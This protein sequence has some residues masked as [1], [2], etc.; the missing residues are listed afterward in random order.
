MTQPPRQSDRRFIWAICTFILCV[1]FGSF[2]FGQTADA[3]AT[4]AD[5]AVDESVQ[6]NPNLSAGEQFIADFAEW[7]RI[8]ERAEGL[9]E[10]DVA[11]A[12][13]LDRLLT[14]LIVW[15]DVFAFEMRENEAR[16]TTI[17]SQTAALGNAPDE[18]ETEA[19]A[20]TDR[21]ADLIVFRDRLA[22]PG[23]LSA[24]G[25]ARALGMINEIE[26]QLRARQ[27]AALM[28]RTVSPF[29]LAHWPF[30]AAHIID[31]VGA[32]GRETTA[33][34]GAKLWSSE[35]LNGL[36]WAFLAL[37]CA[38]VLLVRGQ[39]FVLRLMPE[40]DPKAGTGAANVLADFF[41]T[42][43]QAIVPL[44][45]LVALSYGL[46][47]L[48]IF[49]VRGMAILEVLPL[50]GSII[51]LA[52][53][54]GRQFFPVG[55]K[56]GPLNLS[57]AVRI[58]TRRTAI[59][60]AWVMALWLPYDAFVNS[61]PEN[62]IAVSVLNFPFIVVLAIVLF[63]FAKLFRNPPDQEAGADVGVGRTRTV[64]GRLTQLIAVV[65]P[66]LAALG[67]DAAA[68]AL[69]FPAGLTLGLLGVIIYLQSLS[70][71]VYELWYGVE[72]A[73]SK[74]L[75]P[76]I[77][78]F[79]LLLL[80]VPIFALIWGAQR[81]DLLA[82]WSRFTA[83]FKWGD[84]QISP[85]DFL[86]FVLIFT[87]GYLLT[88]FI[89]TSLRTSV[90]PRTSLDLGAQD[91][92]VAGFGYVGIFL[93]SVIA[94][95][96]AG[97][98]L[99]N[100][101]IVA[102]A[103][104]V[105]I[106]FGLQTIVSNF[107]SGIILLIERPVSQGDWIEVGDRM[108]YVRSISVRSTRI[109]TFDRTDVIVPNADLISNQ[110]IN[111]TR[112]NLVGRLILKIG[113]AY[114]TDVEVV[115]QILKEIAEAHP[116]VVMTPPP[117]IMFMNFGADALEFEIRAILRDVNFVVVVQSEM[118]FEIARRFAAENIEIPFAQRDIWLRNPE[119]LG[120]AGTKDVKTSAT[121]ATSDKARIVD[122]APEDPDAGDM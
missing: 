40:T 54:L 28:V 88:G 24:E 33:S 58:P 43:F 5:V 72:D 73:R 61:G 29:N 94:I 115:A 47:T 22:A 87:V 16:L 80:S 112:G 89:K 36:F 60:L 59:I 42:V 55:L 38:A 30:A 107:V 81:S 62:G 84:F 120:Q 92:I 93:A 85:S 19:T 8:A 26:V 23:L 96:S 71:R 70:Y 78:G 110:V 7:N 109:E 31:G 56:Y 119:A 11:S 65:A 50:T 91:A 2:S 76:V 4:V 95:T 111:W 63:R 74:A 25:N 106:G 45:G 75:V 86:M 18:G 79:V 117:S 100:L 14:E 1:W 20:V 83:G 82:Y 46:A 10:R 103:L 98:D 51:I 69:L 17:A 105:G 44:V 66:V 108:G 3:T 12:F 39:S 34:L 90:L 15:R 77:V 53:W 68:R 113:V 64:V 102:G 35:N 104:S 9:L 6:I 121:D 99:S 67:Y 122:V 13:A 32:I 101:A 116:M 48:D 97:I 52:G 118:N 27:T 49:G 114:G 41:K 21:R 37:G 57:E